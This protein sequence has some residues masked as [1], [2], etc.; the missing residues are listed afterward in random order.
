MRR[1]RSRVSWSWD[2][3]RI[4]CTTVRGFDRVE[5]VEGVEGFEGFDR[6]EGFD[7]VEGCDRFEGFDRFTELQGFGF[8]TIGTFPFRFYNRDS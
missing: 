4:E 8:I 1:R 7:G 5:G 6:F 2:P 3:W